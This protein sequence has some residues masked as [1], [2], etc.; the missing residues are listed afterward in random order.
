M[1]ISLT[2]IGAFTWLVNKVSRP[3]VAIPSPVIRGN[4]R[5]GPA[6]SYASRVTR[7]P[8]RFENASARE[9]QSREVERGSKRL[10]V[11]DEPRQAIRAGM[12]LPPLSAIAMRWA[13]GTVGGPAES[14]SGR[15]RHASPLNAQDAGSKQMAGHDRKQ[16]SRP[17]KVDKPRP[18][19][20]RYVVRKGDSRWKIVRSEWKSTDRTLI[21][22][23]IQ[24]NPQLR[25]GDMIMAGH[26]LIIPLRPAREA[27]LEAK[28]ET[29]RWY[30]IRKNDT[31]TGIARH[32]LNDGRRWYEIARLNRIADASK[33]RAGMRIRLPATGGIEAERDA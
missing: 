31:L 16:P 11:R 5:P 15:S 12:T 20:K 1:L 13:R 2:F 4:R 6:T 33:I 17:V 8:I 23:L 32:F 14:A 19:L 27:A 10:V 28:T 3:L 29:I 9:R 7:S 18:E 21:R 26:T 30:T 22:H 25:G 24:A